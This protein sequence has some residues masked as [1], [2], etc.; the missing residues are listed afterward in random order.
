MCGTALTTDVLCPVCVR[1]RVFLLYFICL[2]V[3]DPFVQVE[4]MGAVCDQ[5][6]KK[7]KYVNDSKSEMI[8]TLTCIALA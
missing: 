3:V 4:I 6:T 8:S 2:Q 1:V 5:D 7:T